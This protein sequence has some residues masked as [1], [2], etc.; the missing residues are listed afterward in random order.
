MVYHKPITDGHVLVCPRRK[1]VERLSDLTEL[2]TLELFVCAQEVAKFFSEEFKLE[3][4]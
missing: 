1:G 2:E 4:V 3:N